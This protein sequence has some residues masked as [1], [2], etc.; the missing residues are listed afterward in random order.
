MP[1]ALIVEDEPEANRLL[2]LLVQLR[3][4]QTESAFSGGEALQCVRRSRPDIVFLDLMLPD[5]N[6]Y[7]VC[8]SL[9][10]RRTTHLIPVVM[11]TARLAAESQL[12]SARV[13]ANEF[14]PKPYTPDQIFGAL[15]AADSWRR[16]LEQTS[17][18][19]EIVLDTREEIAATEQVAR[20]QSL[21]LSR[22][23]WDEESIGQ[24]VAD[25]LAMAQSVLEWGRRHGITSLAQVRYQVQP[26]QLR[27]SVR[28]EGGWFACNDLPHEHG[29][30]RLIDRAHFD[31][32]Q[33][34]E[35]GTLVS[36]H[37]RLPLGPA[38]PAH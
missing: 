11:V 32:I 35:S 7:D 21:L 13:G 2:S 9:K 23:K 17:D 4:Y 37:K 12:I 8:R 14:I 3:G 6:G 30:G 10:E 25:V 5:T 19:G 38:A 22:T 36:F 29:L 16:D 27:I 33:Y 1:S 18:G 28:D 31:E 34:D 20:L 26:D 15:E 24:F